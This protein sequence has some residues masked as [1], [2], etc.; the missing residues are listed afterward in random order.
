MLFL[1]NEIVLSAYQLD[2]SHQMRRN[3]N[4]LKHGRTLLDKSICYKNGV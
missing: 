2:G 3:P 1:R 4:P